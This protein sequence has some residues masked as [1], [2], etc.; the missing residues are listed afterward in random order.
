[1]TSVDDN[2]AVT[3]FTSAHIL[4]NQLGEENDGSV[5]VAAVPF[6]QF[7]SREVQYIYFR[8]RMY[9]IA[10]IIDVATECIDK[11]DTDLKEIK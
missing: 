8:K 3:A 2:E 4:M 1:M 11:F 7:L 5:F 9:D 10:S 6:A